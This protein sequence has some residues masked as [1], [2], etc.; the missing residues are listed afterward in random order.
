MALAQAVLLHTAAHSSRALAAAATGD[1]GDFVALQAPLVDTT[2]GLGGFSSPLPANT[3][4]TIGVDGQA[5]L[6]SSGISAVQL[7]ITALN[8]SGAAGVISVRRGST[9]ASVTALVYGFGD[10]GSVSNTAIVAVSSTGSI[11]LE[12]QTSINIRVDVQGY[13]TAGDPDAGGYVPITP[14]RLVDTTTGTGLSG[15][16][17]LAAGSNTV[18]SAGGVGGIPA[19]AS[20]VFVNFQASS[21][22]SSGYL[23]A[24]DTGGTVP[25]TTLNYMPSVT[26]AI[27]ANSP[28]SSGGQFTIHVGGSSSINLSVDVVGYFTANTTGT[29]SFT[30]AATRLIDSNVPPATTIPANGTLTV[31]VTGVNGVP[32][33]GAGIAAAAVNVHI[34]HTGTASG[35]DVI[36]RA[37]QTE[38]TPASLTYSPSSTMSNLYT[39]GLSAAGTIKIHNVSSD[40]V[41]YAIDLEGWYTSVASA[42]PNNQDQTQQSI[43]LQANPAGGGSWVT[44]EYR[45]GTVANF[46][47]VPVANAKDGNGNSP[48]SWPVQ[49]SGGAFTAYTW[50]IRDT[51]K[52]A[53]GVTTA[54]DTF[55]Q[56]EACYGATSSDPNPV[57]GMPS[58]VQFAQS[59]FGDG[60][61]TQN[62]GPGTLAEL[63]GDYEIDATDSDAGTSLDDLS[64][65]RSL[66]TLAPA[67]AGVAPGA[68]RTDASGVFGPSWTAELSGPDAGDGDLRVTDKASS[69]YLIFTDADGGTSQY[70]ATTPVGTYPISFTGVADAAGDGETVTK[71]NS[72][73]ITMADPD[74]TVTTWIKSGSVWQ[75]STVVEPGSNSTSAYTYNATNLVTR[76]LAPVPSGVSCSTPDTTLGCRSLLLAYETITVSGVN[77]TRLQEVDTSLPQTSGTANKV[78]V[79][80]YDYNSSGQ[81]ADAYDPR[82]SP[83]LKTAYTY[84]TAGRLA[85][86]T[87]PG[88]AA[89]TFGYDSG[90][91]L[92]TVSRPDPSGPTAVTTVVYDI[93]TSGSTAPISMTAST[94]GTWDETGDLPVTGTAVFPP[95]HQPA[96]TTASTVTSSDWPW[97]GIDYLD[98]NGLTVNS[99][100]YGAGAWQIDTSQYDG[101]GNDVWDLTAGNRAQALAPTDDT[102]PY[103]AGLSS[104]VDRA[105]ALAFTSV[106]NPL[107]P[108][109]VSDTFGPT[110]PVTLISGS[111]IDAQTHVSTTYDEGAPNSDVDPNTGTAYDL[112][113][114]TTTDAYNAATDADTSFP[115]AS[116]T[117]TGY[118]IVNSGDT[119]GWT[120]YKPTTS[121]VQMGS[122]PSSADLVTTTRYDSSGRVI[123]TRLPAGPSGGTAQSTMTSYFTATGSGACISIKWAGLT[124][125]VG[126]AAQPSSG[127]PLAVKTYTYNQYDEQ[128]TQTETF[129]SSG[130]VRT[131]TVSHDSAGRLLTQALTVTPSSAGGTAVPTVTDGYSS[132]TGL[133]TTVS[134]GSGGSLVTLTTGYNSIGEPTSYTDAGS[135]TSAMTYDLDGRLTSLN[136]GKGTT[137]Y[138]YDTSSEHR[139]MATTED[140]GVSPAPSTFSASYDAAGNLAAETYPNGLV[141]T[142]HVDNVG[143]PTALAYVK[144]G[145]TWMSFA[146]TYNALGQVRGQTSPQ[147]S[148]TY[149][150]DGDDRLS[151]VQD[152]YSSACVTRNYGFDKDSNRTSL[153]SYPS[154]TGG[155]CSTSTTPTT[156]STSYDQGDRDTNTG[157]SYDD[158]GRTLTVPGADAVGVGSHNGFTGSLTVGYY[159]NDMVASQSQ[160]TASLTFG[161]DP[162]QNRLATM[163]SGGTTTTS[164]YTDDGDSPAWSTTSGTTW[165]R[166]LSDIGGNLAATVDQGG[167]VTLQLA[168][169]HGDTIATA[170]DS[171]TATGTASYSETT[172]YGTPRNP[173]GAYSN[174]GWLGGDERSINDLGGVILMGVRLYNS[175]IGRFLSPD[176]VRG[177]NANAYVYPGD[178]INGRDTTGRTYFGNNLGSWQVGWCISNAPDCHMAWDAKQSAESYSRYLRRSG[179]DADTADAFQH[180]VWMA[181][182]SYYDNYDDA[183]DLGLDHELDTDGAWDAKNRNDTERDLDNDHTGAVAGAHARHRHWSRQH[184]MDYIWDL[185]L[186]NKLVCTHNTRKHKYAC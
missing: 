147:S 176:P 104:N 93:P 145:S 100:G 111:V 72:S 95:T 78:A 118:D 140:V 130:T 135:N 120:L 175:T 122:S 37:D 9:I 56:V 156:T 152:T 38:P 109:Q 68:Q 24:Y 49:S 85:S 126:P 81:L 41:G 52:A 59:A 5:G 142:R 127:K 108:S 106:Y 64:V 173:A 178:P 80:K 101:N 83:Y 28:L 170:A 3:W 54:P 151:T 84:N 16:G 171:T 132:T 107:D 75:M 53:L 103:V 47:N 73:T 167:T 79:A 125:S 157:Y 150:Y 114:T 128:L 184:L 18:V 162:D 6:P 159:A 71:V 186:Q 124:C 86:L 74:G 43:T 4:E 160:S 97:A 66:T 70:Q 15:V 146:D 181:L 174:Y 168:N 63:T 92:S 48:S 141:A 163:T 8:S 148:Q 154:G 51:L 29:G 77:V 2:T 131:A 138:S 183:M 137:T 62:V 82:I 30:P 61:A 113:T 161:L 88:E 129:G 134:T 102:D 136:D 144:S 143:Q 27:G 94:T 19:D 31:Q 67:D 1:G 7:T 40:S 166:D 23:V 14:K 96:G 179:Y 110:H 91:R 20:A 65:G 10:T 182:V 98:V 158:L 33:A 90:G 55:V 22:S 121:T 155:A 26:T 177:G 39:V 36:W 185:Y 133:P 13:Y 115:D 87:P 44:Y 34:R 58:D 139:G 46:A 11:Q 35:Y 32:V 180:T 69:G 45:I 116:I 153:N 60:Y 57:C 112:P 50:N 172:E 42:V 17:K 149:T 21:A 12:T 25:D 123:E 119:S 169:L 164:H 99:A 76:I 105:A 165:T 89:F 117:H